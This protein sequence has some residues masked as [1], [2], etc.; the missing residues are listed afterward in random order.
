MV[1]NLGIKKRLVLLITILTAISVI[2]S[3]ILA[4]SSK[5]NQAPKVRQEQ[6]LW[7]WAATSVS[8]MSWRGRTVSQTSLLLQ[9]KAVQS[10][11]RQLILKLSMGYR[12]IDLVLH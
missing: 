10:M 12:N 2:N 1:K 7:C 9:L 8:I 6:S 4:Y 11:L 3:D 5:T